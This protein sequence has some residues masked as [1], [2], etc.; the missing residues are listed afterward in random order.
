MTTAWWHH[1]RGRDYRF[2]AWIGA[3][4]LLL[5][6]F[7]WGTGIESE[8]PPGGWRK[9]DLGALQRRIEEGE[10]RSVEARWYHRIEEP[11]SGTVAGARGQ[12][13]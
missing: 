11:G 4:L 1:R 12:K 10:L 8:A 13:D 9:I 7:L 2:I 5:V 6:G 3:N